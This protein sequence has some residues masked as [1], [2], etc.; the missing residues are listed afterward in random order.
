MI[1]KYRNFNQLQTYNENQRAVRSSLLTEGFNVDPNNPQQVEAAKDVDRC[2]TRI[3]GM[4]PFYGEFVQHARILFDHPAINTMATDGKNIFVSSEFVSNLKDK[5]TIFVLCHEIL[6]IVLLHHFRMSEISADPNKW[7]YAA[8]YEI[9]P[10][11]ISQGLLTVDDLS[12]LGNGKYPGLYKEEYRDLDAE[13]IYNKIPDPPKP[14]PEDDDDES[15]KKE[16]EPKIGD[17]VRVKSDGSYGKITG[18]NP[19]GSWKIVP[20]TEQEIDDAMSY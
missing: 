5:E 6:H 13:T 15:G 14:E 8:D 17:F 1:L 4:Y 18:L 20:A 16:I 12:K 10:Y 11:L 3:I 7:N 2:I 19:D 9:N